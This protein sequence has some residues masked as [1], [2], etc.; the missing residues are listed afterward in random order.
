[1]NKDDV[2]A[3]LR[4]LAMRIEGDIRWRLDRRSHRAFRFRA[5]VRTSDPNDH[6]L[7]GWYSP[8]SEKLTLAVFR[9][10]RG[11]IYGLCMG[12]SH[13]ELDTEDPRRPHKHYWTD[14]HRDQNRYLPDDISAEWS[15][16][17]QV[18]AEFQRE[19]HLVHDGRFHPPP[20]RLRGFS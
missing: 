5:D 7:E 6:Y 13:P 19:S 3:F 17:V 14:Q 10:D 9:P 16:P 15:N 12:I 11:R 1:M 18:W 2:D 4:S 20:N 8:R